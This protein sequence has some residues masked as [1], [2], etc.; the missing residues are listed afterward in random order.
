MTGGR[1]IGIFEPKKDFMEN[2]K[3]YR[4]NRFLDIGHFPHFLWLFKDMLQELKQHFVF[5]DHLIYNV[6]TWKASILT[7]Y[8]QGNK[9]ILVGVQCRR[10]DYAKHLRMVGG[11]DP[12]GPQFYFTALDIYR[13]KYN[14]FGQRVIFLAVSD[15]YEWIKKTLGHFPDVLFSEEFIDGRLSDEEK[16]GFDLAV[17]A[18]CDHSVFA[19]GTFGLWGAL[20]AGGDVVVAKVK[21]INQVFLKI[22]SYPG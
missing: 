15:D 10:T 9:V 2:I 5:H 4:Y 18:S 1:P 16:P 17:L 19:Y 13:T 11:A 22:A 12:V 14:T 6:D 8:S 20:F 3:E 7:K 21:I